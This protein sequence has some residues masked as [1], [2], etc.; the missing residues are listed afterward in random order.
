MA[1]VG[2]TKGN[3]SWG[4]LVSVVVENGFPVKNGRTEKSLREQKQK[5]HRA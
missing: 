2:S 1:Q 5:N 3:V 4:H